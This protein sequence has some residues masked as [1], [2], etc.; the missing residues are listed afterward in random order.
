MIPTVHESPPTFTIPRRDV[1]VGH[2]RMMFPLC[3]VY[4]CLTTRLH[5][6]NIVAGLLV[7]AFISLIISPPPCTTP[8][9][10]FPVIAIATVNYLA[11][12]VYEVAGC[13]WR[14]A[15]IVLNPSLPLTPG[16]VAIHARRTDPQILA[17]SAHSIT[18]TPGEMVLEVGDDGT[19][20]THTL[21]VPSTTEQS[22]AAQSARLAAFEK[23]LPPISHGAA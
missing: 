20:Y 7:S 2:L 14:V 4:L 1:V 10:A 17:L 5:P 3:M 11:K 12:L 9:S 19:L 22:A 15:K 21:N 16:I 8:L 13:G 18:V 6:A 23:I